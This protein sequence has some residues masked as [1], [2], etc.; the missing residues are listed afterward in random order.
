MLAESHSR[1]LQ[2][3]GRA[4]QPGSLADSLLWD[5]TCVGELDLPIVAQTRIADQPK[6]LVERAAAPRRRRVVKRAARRHQGQPVG[7]DHTRDAVARQVGV[8]GDLVTLDDV[9]E[10]DGHLFGAV[11]H[12]DELLVGGDGAFLQ[13]DLGTGVHPEVL[14][15]EF[16]GRFW[17]IEIYW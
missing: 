7:V 12:R 5:Q 11:A 15:A 8:E 10:G 13:A 2:H 17:K 16:G 9:L 4:G 6:L 1:S 14:R 3:R